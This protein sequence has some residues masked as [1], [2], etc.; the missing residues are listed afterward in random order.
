[1]TNN[2]K[3]IFFVKFPFFFPLT[4][5]FILYFFPQ[6]ETALIFLT[7]LL[8]AE[9]HFGATWPFM[10]NKTNMEYIKS[11]KTEFIYIPVFIAII[12]LISFFLIKNIFLLIFFAANIYHVTRQSFGICKLY[13]K[14]S[15]E[16][17]F[18]ENF[19]YISNLVFFCI[20]FLRFYLQLITKEHLIYLNLIIFVFISILFIIYL[21]KFK[22]SENFLTFC[23]GCLIF[24]PAC[25]VNNPVH[26]IIMGVTM[27][28]TQYLYLTNKVYFSRLKENIDFSFNLK[29]F[30]SS[31]YFL[32]ILV[33]SLVMSTL[34]IFGKFD[35]NILKNLL[36]IPIVGQMLHFYLDSQLWKFSEKH[37]RDNILL[38][39]TK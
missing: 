16:I 14:E 25:F 7:I 32:I 38:H 34:S 10:I 29:S 37:N 2:F 20:A 8:L 39:L 27:H 5:I 13:C 9:T 26:V 21:Y 15:K 31:R 22:F 23:T 35:Q 4:Y 18:Q 28:Y 33:Y 19:I 12:S 1:M 17:K 6:F 36:I 24:S 11:K 30:L 3:E